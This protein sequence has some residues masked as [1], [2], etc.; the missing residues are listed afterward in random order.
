MRRVPDDFGRVRFVPV[1]DMSFPQEQLRHVGS[2]LAEVPRACRT[3]DGL[4]VAL[5]RAWPE[6]V[7]E[8]E[9]LLAGLSWDE[10]VS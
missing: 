8:V 9:S 2:G 3:T 10:R 5:V 4:P 6:G 1:S 7:V